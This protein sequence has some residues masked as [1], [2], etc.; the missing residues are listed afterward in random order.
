[1][2]V[3][4][5]EY[6]NSYFL[7]ALYKVVMRSVFFDALKT[8]DLSCLSLMAHDPTLNEGSSLGI[9]S[10]KVQFRILFWHNLVNLAK[11]LQPT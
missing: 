6:T 10:S 7:F 2:D 8:K 11:H 4:H 1:M 3:S 9:L 5:L